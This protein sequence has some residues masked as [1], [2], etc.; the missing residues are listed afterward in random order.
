M[1]V[2][3]LISFFLSLYCFTVLFFSFFFSLTFCIIHH[4]SIYF[5]V[6]CSC[7]P[8]YMHLFHCIATYI[9]LFT[10]ACLEKCIVCLSR[11]LC[12]N[13]FHLQLTNI[14]VDA[15]VFLCIVTFCFF[16]PKKKVFSMLLQHYFLFSLVLFD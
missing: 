14:I 16:F 3:H 7:N 6:I 5:F 15:K 8:M 2:F 12:V 11:R 13:C 1:Y 10:R 9:S 4:Y